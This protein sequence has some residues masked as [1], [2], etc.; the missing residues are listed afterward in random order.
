[1]TLLVSL[2][3]SRLKNN[4]VF[5]SFSLTSLVLPVIY[6]TVVKAEEG[7]VWFAVSSFFVVL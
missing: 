4:L 2:Q 1:M 3:P 5:F 6:I 7:P